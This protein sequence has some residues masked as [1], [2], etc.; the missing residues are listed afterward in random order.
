MISLN[1]SHKICLHPT[2]EL[3]DINCDTSLGQIEET[4]DVIATINMGKQF[5]I[6]PK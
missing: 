3:P 1:I 2:E 4:A 5:T 6:K